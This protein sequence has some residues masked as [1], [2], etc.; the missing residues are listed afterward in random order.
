MGAR[1]E[2]VIDLRALR[3]NLD[4]LAGPAC[5]GAEVARMLVV[6]A[7]GYGHGAAPVARVAREVGIPWLGVALPT[8]VGDGLDHVRAAGP[9]GKRV[10]QGEP[11]GGE[12]F[13]ELGAFHAGHA[14]TV[15]SALALTLHECQNRPRLPL[16]LSFRGC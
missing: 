10:E 2:A 13:D 3:A 11:L 7:D 12:Q 1:A 9:R 14:S 15:A 4:H 8:E 16:A 6:K 5:G